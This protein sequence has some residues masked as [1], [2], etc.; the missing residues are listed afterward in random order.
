MF[1]LLICLFTHFCQRDE[2]VYK[3]GPIIQDVKIV[4]IWFGDL[5]NVK[6]KREIEQFYTTVVKS[7]WFT[8][9]TEYNI[10]GGSWE[11]SYDYN[12][13]GPKIINSTIIADAILN[14]ARRYKST[15]NY[16]FVI[17]LSSEI[18]VMTDLGMSCDKFYAYHSYI[19]RIAYG[20]IPEC[21][22]DGLN[23]NSFDSI[24][25]SSSHELA[26]TVIN[27]DLHTGWESES[28]E[29]IAD[30]CNTKILT[31]NGYKLNSLYSNKSK[32][33]IS[34]MSLYAIVYLAFY[35]LAIFLLMLHVAHLA[36]VAHTS[37]PHI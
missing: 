29:E 8:T 13:T 28:S 18:S 31:V 32:R 1:R 10:S 5:H 9:L 12:Y 37:V 4:T 24:T 20:V 11:R 15:L 23:L 33:C 25:H 21:I 36:Y 14:I 2:L 7:D 30:L 27:P 17:H 19:N 26:E 6:Y 34:D 35:S 22:N 3:G 16:Y